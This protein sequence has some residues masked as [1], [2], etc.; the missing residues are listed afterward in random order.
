MTDTTHSEDWTAGYA[1]DVPYTTQFYREQSPAWIN[2]VCL[3]NGV[4][5][6][7]LHQPFAYFELGSGRGLTAQVLAAGNP[8]GQFYAADF[9]PAHVA[10]AT[11][12]AADAQLNNLTLLENSFAEL[13]AGEIVLPQFDFITMHGVYTWVNEEN[14]RHIVRFVER[15]LKP[16]GLLYVSYNA[17]PGWSAAL[18][19]QRL[20]IEYA[21]LFPNRTDLQMVGANNL[22]EML[23]EVDAAYLTQNPALA[24]RIEGMRTAAPSYMVHEYMH[25]HWQP[26]Y[27]ADVAGDLAAAKLSYAGSADLPFAYPALYLTPER[28]ALLDQIGSQAVRETLVDYFFNTSFR[29]DV[30]VRGRCRLSAAR[31]AQLLGTVGVAMMV[32]RASARPEI[33]MKFGTFDGDPAT[34]SAVLDALAAGP[35]TLDELIVLPALAHLDLQGLA[36]IAVLL[37]ASNQASLYFSGPADADASAH[38]AHRLNRTLAGR[39]ADGGDYP[40]LCAP[41]LQGGIKVTLH[42]RLFYL[43][44]LEPGATPHA[45]ALARFAWQTLAPLR[46]KSL[47]AGAPADA[48]LDNLVEIKKIAATFIAETLPVW[49]A[50]H[51]V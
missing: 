33:Q 17:M 5:P 25:R 51:I 29:K 39:S 20:V 7:A 18:P 13:A 12:L 15:Y 38:A 31:Q 22:I 43:G 23:G 41:L 30:F 6:V 1:S 47:R 28:Q 46:R 21:G 32:P 27:H 35:R 9:N 11:R 26:L 45:D 8:S 24:G 42:E 36:Q 40:V 49:Q 16:G 14:R 3:I 37:C 19:L 50:L 48:Q 10:E 34:Y 4:E 44:L 2:L